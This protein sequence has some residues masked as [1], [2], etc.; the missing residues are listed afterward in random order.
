MEPKTARSVRGACA[1][2]ASRAIPV[3]YTQEQETAARDNFGALRQRIGARQVAPGSR[4]RGPE[5]AGE[6]SVPR[7]RVC[8][9]QGSL[10]HLGLVERTPN[11]GALVEHPGLPQILHIYDLKWVLEALAARQAALRAPKELWRAE[12][13]RFKGLINE[14]VGRG[15]F[16]RCIARYEAIRRRIIER[17]GNPLVA[18]VPNIIF[19]KTQALIRGRRRGELP[20]QVCRN[21]GGDGAGRR[22]GGAERLRRAGLR[23]GRE[24][25]TKFQHYVL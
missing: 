22:R 8:D 11:C 14:Y 18:D 1:P 6:I 24:S 5:F 4:L 2:R 10:E 15:E 19:E 7:V 25:V 12:H 17:A 21:A 3:G 9:D 13:E 20:A 23:S 16:D